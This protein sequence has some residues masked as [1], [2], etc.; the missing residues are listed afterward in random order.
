MGSAQSLQE[1][2]KMRK[3]AGISQ[4]VGIPALEA[5][6]GKRTLEIRGTVRGTF[7]VQGRTVLH[8]DRGDGD[9]IDVQTEAPPDWLTGNTVTARLLIR[10]ERENE[11]GEIRA[12]LIGAASDA[13]I[14]RIEDAERKKAE[15]A[16]KRNRPKPGQSVTAPPK[17][18][19]KNWNLP[20]SEVT[21]IY[22]SF[23]KSRNKR[24]TDSEAMRIA[25]S[26]VGFSIMYGVDARLIMAMV[27]VESGFD[28][29][30]RSSA[31]A[32][33]LGQ[34]MPGTAKSF[35]LTNAYDSV[36]NLYGT[37]RTIRGHLERYGKKAQ[38]GFEALIISLAAY[39]AGSGNVR[40]HGG[41]PPF[42]QTQNY[43]RKVVGLYRAFT[44]G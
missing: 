23:I 27:M 20:A 28:P 39:N 3:D 38:D 37:V 17:S 33:G 12:W 35:G 14:T 8:V 24:L 42:Q 6:V 18:Q 41:V 22:A 40:R 7:S 11:L 5:F 32:M 19:V 9:T 1:Y 21:P 29:N 10:A 2:L 16:A 34:L 30:A 31:G 4:S 43:I 25:Q 44:G 36:Q 26:I 15:A 13:E